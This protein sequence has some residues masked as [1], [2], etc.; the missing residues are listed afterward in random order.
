MAVA[1]GCSQDNCGMRG[2][3]IP[4]LSDQGI[5]P[6]TPYNIITL[7]KSQHPW[8][9]PMKAIAILKNANGSPERGEKKK[10]CN[11]PE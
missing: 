11:T 9:R 1:N 8:I 6:F 2:E 10:R 7:P 3:T 4:L 5:K